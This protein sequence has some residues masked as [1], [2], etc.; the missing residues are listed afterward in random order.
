MSNTCLHLDIG[1]SVQIFGDQLRQAAAYE[2][3]EI[4]LEPTG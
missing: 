4:D 2:I 3:S 1:P